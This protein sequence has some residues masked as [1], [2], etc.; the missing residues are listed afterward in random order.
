MIVNVSPDF[1]MTEPP[2]VNHVHPNVSNVPL[3]KHAQYV[4]AQELMPLLVIAQMVNGITMEL[5]K[6]VT[7]CVN[8]VTIV[9]PIVPNQVTVPETELTNPPVTVPITT[10]IIMSTL[11]VLNVAVN[12]LLAPKMDVLPVPVSEKEPT[13]HAHQELMK[14]PLIPLETKDVPTDLKMMEPVFHVH[15][16]VAPVLM[17]PLVTPVIML[18]TTEKALPHVPV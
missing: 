16:S 5:V 4:L 1:M 12:V 15:T 9:P 14:P 13:V 18:I 17:D 8:T 7:I 11:N 3:M 10:M 2:S 6:Y